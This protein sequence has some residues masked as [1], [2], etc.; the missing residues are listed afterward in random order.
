MD[1]L[2]FIVEWAVSGAMD[3]TQ[4]EK[5]RKRWVSDKVCLRCLGDIPWGFPEKQ[6]VVG[7][8]CRKQQQN[9][10]YYG[11]YISHFNPQAAV[12]RANIDYTSL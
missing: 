11:Q 5:R 9:K 3:A 12:Q 10:V 6:F 2:L 7:T 8:L 4:Q 1:P